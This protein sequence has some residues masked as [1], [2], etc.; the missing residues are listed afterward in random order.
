MKTLI[1][2]LQR[3]HCQKNCYAIRYFFLIFTICT[4]TDI[5]AQK[6]SEFNAALI[7]ANLKQ[8]ANAV[9]R[10]EATVVDMRAPDNV[11]L[12]VTQAITVLNKNAERAATLV[13][14]Y[15]KNTTIKSVKGQILN[16][17]GEQVAKFTLSNFI[18]QSAVSDFSLFE[19]ARVK[20]YAPNS[21]AY[22][23]TIV[24][25]YEIRFKQNLNIPVWYAIPDL[26]IAVEKS[27]Y[28]FISRIDD[29][30][31]I[32]EYNYSGKPQIIEKD[33]VISRTWELK[34]IVALRPEPYARQKDFL[35][36]V[37]IAP[38]KF[39]YY[40]HTGSYNNWEELGKWIY[41]DLIKD[42]QQL[43]EKTVQQ[44]KSL[45]KDAPSEKEKVR[46]IYNYVQK[47][48]RYIS[49]QVGI[50]GYQ[51][52]PASD[53]D[54]LSYGDCKALVN[55]TQSLLKAAEI[56]SYYCVVNA[57]DIKQSLDPEFSS[58][59]QAN[60]IILCVPLKNDTTWLECT[61]QDI[62]FGYL[63]SF[64]DDRLILACTPDGGKLLRTPLLSTENNL[65]KRIAELTLDNDGNI[66]GA[67][68]TNF[69]GSQYENYQRL[70]NKPYTEQIKLLKGEYDIDNIN[71][72]DFK[73]TQVKDANPLT[74][75]SL[76]LTIQK[77]ASKANN[78][79]YL[80][81]NI[82][83]KMFSI[84]ELRNRQAPISINRGFTDEDVLI[85]QLPENYKI[86]LKPEDKVI[87]SMFGTY[88]FSLEIQ[89]NKLICKRKLVL[90]NG[91]YDASNYLELINFINTI[92]SV[93]N[94]KIVFK[95]D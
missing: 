35:T 39:T 17:S 47:K 18:D 36:Y 68:K 30:V 13:L 82:F 95:T 64:T 80:F 31:R 10:S 75:E 5:Q 4:G 8:R 70:F 62:P 56:N 67:L 16:S 54:Q 90:K 41:D 79:I 42:R 25:D 7:P 63:G 61:S 50:G 87:N 92:S 77:Y 38:E 46:R 2:S 29:K 60:H 55:Y 44:I 81:P 14:N 9:V 24:Y 78:H 34:N 69:S 45:V 53:V 76:N 93:D 57:G 26:N 52:F 27:T 49:V 58:M 94:S 65:L 19:D 71:F 32:K 74:I 73:L 88:N 1:A 15:D 33:K 6:I 3:W 20:Y 12:T 59:D 66:S 11:I 22:P 51:P 37:K 86:E 48:T 89:N 23:Y 83:N 40:G 28:T 85:Y 84:P 91:I 21:N 43:S 72:S